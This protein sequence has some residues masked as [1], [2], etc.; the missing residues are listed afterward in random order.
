MRSC[1]QSSFVKAD[2]RVEFIFFL[3]ALLLVMKTTEEFGASTAAKKAQ[4]NRQDQ[5]H[6]NE[7]VINPCVTFFST[8][9]HRFFLKWR[10]FTG[11][12]LKD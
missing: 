12:H 9:Q 3:Y 10:N 8:T 11:T 6:P 4:W 1:V 2:I 7:S 5:V